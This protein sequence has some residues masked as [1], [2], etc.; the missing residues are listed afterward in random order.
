MKAKKVKLKSVP[1]KMES[2]RKDFKVNEIHGVKASGYVPP[3]SERVFREKQKGTPYGRF[4]DKYEDLD[5]YIDTFNSNELVWYFREVANEN[6]FKYMISNYARESKVMKRLRETYSNR[7][8]CGMIEFLYTS[9]QDY[10]EKPRLSV[11]LLGSAWINT[12]Y[13]DFNLW[14]DDKYEPKSVWKNKKRKDTA[15]KHEWK[16]NQ[17]SRVGEW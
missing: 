11:N 4:L 8:I 12:I 9:E 16:S 6:G 1:V 7:E 15:E 10:L 14:L 3:K 13:A 5:N 2:S 17:I